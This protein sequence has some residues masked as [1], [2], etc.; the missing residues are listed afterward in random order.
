VVE[1]LLAK[2]KVA[3]S[4]PVFRSPKTRVKTPG[5]FFLASHLTYV[6]PA[7]DGIPLAAVLVFAAGAQS[8]LQLFAFQKGPRASG[9]DWRTPRDGSNAPC[10][11]P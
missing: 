10:C 2:E 8:H 9:P 6:D 5:N 1:H 11:I 7:S 4:N 3:G